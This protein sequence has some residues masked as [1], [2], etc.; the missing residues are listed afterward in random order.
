MIRNGGLQH[1]LVIAAF[2]LFDLFQKANP[3][4]FKA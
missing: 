2:E 1:A 4:L 3:D